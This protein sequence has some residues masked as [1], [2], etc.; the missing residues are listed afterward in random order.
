MAHS[1]SAKVSQ[2]VPSCSRTTMARSE[3]FFS[4]NLQLHWEVVT[5]AAVRL[6][7]TARP[8]GRLACV[9]RGFRSCLSGG[10]KL[11][12]PAIETNRLSSLIEGLA[13]VSMQ[14]LEVLRIDLAAEHRDCLSRQDIERAVRQLSGNLHMARSL[15]V[16][17]IRMASFD[18]AM[19]RLRL[20]CD[21]W[22]VLIHGLAALAQHGR[23]R[24]L[25]LSSFSIKEKGGRQLRRAISAPEP[26]IGSGEAAMAAFS[27][28]AA[29][30]DGAKLTLSDVLLRMVVLEDLSLTSD[31]IY[32]PTAQ[33]LSQVLPQLRHLKKVD[34]T[35]NHISKQVMDTVRAALP[36]EVK[37]QGDSQ[38]TV[39][40]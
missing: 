36:A 10:Q 1:A 25:E 15:R 24:S 8:I 23:L 19:E 30:S 9:S 18:S 6:L 16:L 4:G 3:G 31:G 35:R 33:Q 2:Q 14:D 34:L 29:S 5:Y 17:S 28:G 21:T 12:V 40:C 27:G 20:S 38:Q 32:P 39:C 22:E 37:L 7:E 11:R 26:A 13:R